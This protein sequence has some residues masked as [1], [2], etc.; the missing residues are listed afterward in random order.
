MEDRVPEGLPHLV[1]VGGI[2]WDGE[3]LEGS[4]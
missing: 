2:H 4:Q 1:V 3:P